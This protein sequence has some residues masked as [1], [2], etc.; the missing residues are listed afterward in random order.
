MTRRD[1]TPRPLLQHGE[2][3]SNSLRFLFFTTGLDPTL[4]RLAAKINQV[5]PL[6]TPSPCWRGGRGVRSPYTGSHP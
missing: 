4:A 1:L 6:D 2:G 5:S 3:V